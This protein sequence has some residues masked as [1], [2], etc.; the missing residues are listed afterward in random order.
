MDNKYYVSFHIQSVKGRLQNS[1][2]AALIFASLLDAA[3]LMSS[4]MCIIT[5]SKILQTPLCLLLPN[6]KCTKSPFSAFHYG[7]HDI[8]DIYEKTSLLCVKFTY[9][10]SQ[11]FHRVKNEHI[12]ARSQLFSG[13]GVCVCRGGR[14]V[15]IVSKLVPLSCVI[16]E[17]KANVTAIMWC[18]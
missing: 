17:I 6:F 15:R 16:H 5:E 1:L 14:C 13:L 9:T 11:P 2:A 3:I 12:Q 10:E 7:C 8:V 4:L 18:K